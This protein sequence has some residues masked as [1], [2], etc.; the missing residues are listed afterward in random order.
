MTFLEAA[1]EI[2][3]HER[4]PIHFAEIT[5]RA[6]DRKLLSHV[7]RDP[8]TAMQTCLNS[9]VR[10]GLMTRDKPGHFQLRPGAD[11][12]ELPVP[13]GTRA[14]ALGIDKVP[15]K[16]NGTALAAASGSSGGSGRAGSKGDDAGGSDDEGGGRGRSK[17]KSTRAK[18]KSAASEKVTKKK[19][20]RRTR[21]KTVE[22][23]ETDEIE[24]DEVEVEADEVEVE[25]D[26]VEVSEVEV[27]EVEA[28]D[29][30]A[31]DEASDDDDDDDA[32]APVRAPEGVPPLP[33]LDPS[34]IRF[35]GPQGSGLEG[36]TDIAL[37]MANAVSR[38]VHERPELRS[39]LEAM[40][41]TNPAGSAGSS[42]HGS[43][44]HASSSSGMSSSNSVEVIEVRKRVERRDDRKD[45][46]DDDRGGR[47]RRRRR[48]RARRLEWSEGGALRTAGAGHEELLDKVA[49]VLG[50]AGTRSLHIRQIAENLAA[51]NVL[52]GEISEIERAVTASLLLDVH[53]RGDASRFAVRGDARY[54]L[55]GG[56][57][58]EKAAAAEQV[59]RRALL[60]LEQESERQLLQWLQALGARSLEALVRIWL[61]REEHAIVASLAPGRGLGKLVVEDPE[62][63]DEDGRLLVLVVPRKTP[64]EA[65][66]W[67]GEAERNG[68]SGILLFAMGEVGELGGAGPEPRWIG[69]PEL[70]RWLIRQRIGVRVAR[71]E[72]PVLDADLIES[73]AGLDT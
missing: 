32:P 34:K 17:K 52:G 36:E 45:A 18:K 19:T 64:V 47:R 73:I 39:E 59:A 3:R 26:E 54:Q 61:D 21:A 46:L 25:T 56:R 60:S 33:A 68:C 10:T 11:L 2:L 72:V 5:K 50:E 37:V 48:R 41:R 70:A 22:A 6:V 49:Q 13:P 27:S 66:L 35:R 15:A 63:D 51:Q 40:Q 38:L 4:E 8:E 43:S 44:S 28:D 57:V 16:P 29:E 65:K 62:A 71:F 1:I 12:P 55:R 31:A 14:A 23:E 24:A 67:E 7:G 58:P 42:S 30:P 53:R 69:A 9:A 20:A